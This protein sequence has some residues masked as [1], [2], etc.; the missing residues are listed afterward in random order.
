MN[1]TCLLTRLPGLAAHLLALVA[2]T[3]ALVR[4]RRPDLADVRGHL[5]DL[6]LVDALDDE[7]G[8]SLHPEG[9]PLRGP[10]RH[11]VAE[12]EGE[13][14]VAALGY[15]AVPGADD[16]QRLGVALRDAGHHVGH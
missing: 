7:P 6:L 9:D 5:A 13:L 4:L 14:Q 10:H 1:S 11:G 3:L 15:H 12:P 2:D 16:L 8:R